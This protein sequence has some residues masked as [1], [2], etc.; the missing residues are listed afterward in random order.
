VNSSEPPYNPGYG[1]APPVLAGRGDL[2]AETM[3]AL[4]AGPRHAYF[5]RAVI[6]DRGV[7]KTVLLNE[8]E[9]EVDEQLGWSVVAH[10]A[11]PGGALVPPL[12][13]RLMESVSSR[14]NKAGR[15]FKALEKDV[16]VS[17]NLI[18]V[19]AGATVRTGGKA[20]TSPAIALER[21]FRSVGTFAQER[22]SGV[23]VTI[24][25][26]QVIPKAPD[27][28]ALGAALQ[29][30]VK[31]ARLPVAVILA[32]L[33]SLRQ[34]FRGVGT[35][36]ER[37]DV[38]ALSY[39]S[40]DATYRALTQ[41]AATEGV[42]FDADAIEFL[43]SQ[44]DGYPY[45]VQL[46][47]FH[48]WD[49]AP[50]GQRISLSAAREGTGR[51]ME[52]L[53]ATFQARWDSLSDLERKYVIA[54]ANGGDGRASSADVHA[55]L[56]RSAQQLSTTRHALIGDHGLLRSVGRGEMVVT[57]PRFAQWVAKLT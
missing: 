45:L 28:A 12:V 23:L 16:S 11:I 27:L 5:G 22:H 56:G 44:S 37:L 1:V 31:R 33:P 53:E 13:E 20:A 36:L 26:A 51:A 8:L 7:G 2:L 18:V 55:A 50:D 14:W 4:L 42:I 47:G 41:P 19:Q 25:E 21:I 30:V 34:S 32:G 38:V 49:A 43:V 52:K 46:L 57:L 39:L 10:Q 17:T 35:F 40:A 29:L 24:D 6:G 48:T 54:V 3:R 9:R 15:A